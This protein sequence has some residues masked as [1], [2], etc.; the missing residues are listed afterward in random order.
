M[1][2]SDYKPYQHG[3][4]FRG[5]PHVEQQLSTRECKKLIKYYKGWFVRNLYDFDCKDETSFWFVIN[6]K[7]LTIS[8]LSSKARNQV[9]RALHTLDIR[10]MTKAEILMNGYEVYRASYN[11]Y[12][13]IIEPPKQENVWKNVIN[14]S[15]A[16]YWGAF[17]KETGKL[18]AYAEVL[19]QSNMAKYTALKG[20][21][22]YLNK[23]Y[24]FYGLLFVMNEYYIDQKHFFYV[25]DGARSVTEHSNVQSFFSKFKFRKAYCK[26]NIQYVW[27][28]KILIYIC[29]PIKKYIPIRKMKYLLA[30]EAMRRNQL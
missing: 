5:A 13:N 28:L 23:Y 18:I 21:P 6:D 4:I 12:K 17:E 25:T 30:F 3:V 16:E 19:C 20:I 10:F 9:R 22:E 11:R 2:I 29:Y 24:P 26:L 14:N 27:W 1:T 8:D 15:V 7:T